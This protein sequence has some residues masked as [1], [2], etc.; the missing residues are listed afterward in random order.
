[1][2]RQEK[3]GVSSVG[4]AASPE[5]AIVTSPVQ[6]GDVVQNG[7]VVVVETEEV[8]GTDHVAETEEV[9]G[10]GGKGNG[11][12]LRVGGSS[13]SHLT[14]LPATFTPPWLADD[15]VRLAYIRPNHLI[16]EPSAG[17]GNIVRAI[18]RI[19]HGTVHA[20]ELNAEACADLLDMNCQV[21]KGDF[22][23]MAGGM[24]AIYDR[25]VMNPPGTNTATHVLMAAALLKDGGRI[26]ALVHNAILHQLSHH[27]L[28]MRTYH[29]PD[30]TFVM[31]GMRRAASV[32]VWDE[33]D[34]NA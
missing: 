10:D 11:E 21:S 26:V 34:Y 28:G 31:D 12:T 8:T 29:L 17:R 5:D 15:M 7:T 18:H 19:P 3:S 6:L 30:D 9:H 20:V 4:R 14:N 2:N 32:I 24:R 23:K 22:L 33:S 16:L 25:V 1:M 13:P 27:L